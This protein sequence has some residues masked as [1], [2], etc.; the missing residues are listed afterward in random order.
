MNIR[1]WRE[2]KEERAEKEEGRGKGQGPI[3]ALFPT[4]SLTTYNIH[5]HTCSGTT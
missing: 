3:T 1:Q 2:E 4:S 5:I